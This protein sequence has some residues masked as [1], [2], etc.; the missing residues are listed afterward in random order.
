MIAAEAGL[1]LSEVEFDGGVKRLPTLTDAELDCIVFRFGNGG[2]L[3]VPLGLYCRF[4]GGGN[5]KFGRWAVACRLA[6]RLDGAFKASREVP[7]PMVGPA[8]AAI[9]V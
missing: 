8:T 1:T 2:Y 5:S 4:V 9:L 7:I 6:V 3:W